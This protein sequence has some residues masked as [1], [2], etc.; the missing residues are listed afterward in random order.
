MKTSYDTIQPIKTLYTQVEQVIN[1]F[2]AA[3]TTFTPSQMFSMAYNLVF[4]QDYTTTPVAS[5][6]AVYRQIKPWK[7]SNPIIPLQTKT[8]ANRD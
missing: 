8:C 7:F 6:S 4:K 3:S 1:I 2:N 5:S